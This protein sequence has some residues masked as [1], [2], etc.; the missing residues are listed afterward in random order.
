M[1]AA[2]DEVSE[3]SRAMNLLSLVYTGAGG[4]GGGFDKVA[5]GRIDVLAH[6]ET[7]W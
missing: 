3:L 4:G 6:G 1:A 7:V 2:M 5:A